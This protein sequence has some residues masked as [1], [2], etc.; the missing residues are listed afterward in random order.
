MTQQM[1]RSC[2]WNGGRESLLSLLKFFGIS[3]MV[4]ELDR[5][6]IAKGH[7]VGDLTDVMGH[8]SKVDLILSNKNKGKLESTIF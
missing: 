8:I 2:H 5:L 1:M 7:T 4:L 6:D 3:Q